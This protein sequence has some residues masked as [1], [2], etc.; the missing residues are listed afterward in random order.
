MAQN[1]AQGGS[2]ASTGKK[3]SD[4]AWLVGSIAVTV[5]SALYLLYS[6]P[7]KKP[8]HHSNHHSG[9]PALKEEEGTS[10]GGETKSQIGSV[11][12]LVS[13]AA[14]D[15]RD[16]AKEN[17]EEMGEKASELYGGAK[18]REEA[19][20]AS[21]TDSA[22]SVKEG[23]GETSEPVTE[24]LENKAHGDDES[25]KGDAGGPN[26]GQEKMDPV[27]EQK[28][29]EKTGG[30]PKSSES[31]SNPPAAGTKGPASTNEKSGK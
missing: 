16:Q 27:G 21:A 6:S 13:E 29:V 24:G 14:E 3:S 26:Q 4:A 23:T 22:T 5:P 11:P 1:S 12:E 30:D 17:F 15:I 2:H 18:G 7:A 10:S 19:S 28:N 8:D 31:L 25:S 9:S 20:T